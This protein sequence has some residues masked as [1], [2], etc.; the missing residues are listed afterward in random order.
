MSLLPSL[1]V[2]DLAFNKISK[3]EA[4]TFANKTH[5]RRVDLKANDI[6]R[7]PLAALNLDLRP[8]S[9]P[10]ICIV[11]VVGVVLDFVCTI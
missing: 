8:K 5:L 4:V 9:K 11:R 1:Q 7:L 2:V 10:F 6:E 3:V